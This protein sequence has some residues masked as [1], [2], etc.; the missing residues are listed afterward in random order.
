[1]RVV[2]V[3][4]GLLVGLGLAT[5]TVSA[6]SEASVE[7]R[8]WQRAT[9]AHDLYISARPAGGSWRT[10]GT[11]PL[12]MSGLNSRG[13]FS[14]GDIIVEVP[15]QGSGVPAQVD[16]QVRVWQSVA[17]AQSL[18][19]S[20][21]PEGGSWR[22][23]GTI[24][25][26]MS[27]LSSR[28]T[29]RFGDVALAAR[30]PFLGRG[31]TDGIWYEARY[32]EDGSLHSLATVTDGGTRWPGDGESSFEFRC[33]EG[34]LDTTVHI[35]GSHEVD[36]RTLVELSLDGGEPIAERWRVDL[37]LVGDY[38]R[39]PDAEALLERFVG[40]RSLRIRLIDSDGFVRLTDEGDLH[41]YHLDVSSLLTTPVQ[42]NLERCGEEGW[43]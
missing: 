11:I 33:F 32:R 12:D 13:T 6:Q 35:R 7:V 3:V 36:H 39:A 22:A 34:N 21:R 1:M 26:D 9:N 38:F 24:P 28:G 2:V 29:F 40:A 18:Y 31:Q 27:S 41:I 14:Y 15:L 4:V 37:G 8:V 43:R 5:T 16:V 30:L 25:L 17:D 19:I 42:M 10:L 20:A 23:L